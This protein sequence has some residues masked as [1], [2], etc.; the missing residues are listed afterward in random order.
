MVT[1]EERIFKNDHRIFMQ[2]LGV[3]KIPKG[4]Y[5]VLMMD[6]KVAMS[7]LPFE[8]EMFKDFI[9]KAEGEV[10]IA[11]LGLGVLIERILDKVVKIVCVEKNQEII[12]LIN[13][14]NEKVE[15]VCDDIFNY[16]PSQKFDCIYFDIWS[17]Y[18]EENLK[19]MILLEEKFKPF[20]KGDYIGS[21]SRKYLRNIYE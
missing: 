21:W 3:V 13:V 5:K 2:P 7:T 19:D 20:L 8:I 16:K 10:L 12:N 14:R 4:N 15:I 17:S 1:I 9:D 11:G 18:S 6:G